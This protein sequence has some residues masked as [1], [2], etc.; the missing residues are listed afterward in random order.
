MQETLTL[1]L[2]GRAVL[3]RLAEACLHATKS[4]TTISWEE[5]VCLA[6]VC[7]WPP[8]LTTATKTSSGPEGCCGALP[9]PWVYLG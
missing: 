7:R 4:H 3:A 9:T 1:I 5:T 8:Q 2:R 6:P